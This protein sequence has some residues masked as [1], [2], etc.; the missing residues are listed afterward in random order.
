MLLL[1]SIQL[2]VVMKQT[3]QQGLRVCLR[4]LRFPVTAL[5]GELYAWATIHW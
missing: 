1:V 5:S 4:Q 3:G 2:S